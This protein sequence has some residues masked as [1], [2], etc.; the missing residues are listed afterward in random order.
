MYQIRISLSHMSRLKKYRYS[1]F[2]SNYFQLKL[3]HMKI[4]TVAAFISL[5]CISISCMTQS[6]PNI[7]VMLSDDMGWGQVDCQGLPE[8]SLAPGRDRY[9]DI[10]DQREAIAPERNRSQYKNNSYGQLEVHRRR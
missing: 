8:T 10:A 7:V 6:R 3:S 4:K 2:D 5:G 1:K 9:L